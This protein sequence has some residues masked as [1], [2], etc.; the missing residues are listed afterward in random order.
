MGDLG[1]IYIYATTPNKELSY[2]FDIEEQNLMTAKIRCGTLRRPIENLKLRF[3]TARLDGNNV[4]FSYK[5]S[6]SAPKA[7]GQLKTE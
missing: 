6:F 7:A 1:S 4:E 2:Y 3:M 5:G